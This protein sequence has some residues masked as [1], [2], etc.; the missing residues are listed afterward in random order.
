M[1]LGNPVVRF[2]WHYWRRGHF[3]GHCYWEGK[4]E[5]REEG[6]Y[7]NYSGTHW[8]CFSQGCMV[9][10]E[11]G[12]VM[13]LCVA[14]GFGGDRE[15][16]SILMLQRNVVSTVDKGAGHPVL[17]PVFKPGVLKRHMGCEGVETLQHASP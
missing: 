7:D 4:G 10:Q 1:L 13:P 3:G 6:K 15:L 16:V 17:I 5:L 11:L 12:L 8:L 14:H 9:E 2:I